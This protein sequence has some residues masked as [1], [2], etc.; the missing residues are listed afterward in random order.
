MLL[1]KHIMMTSDLLATV[2]PPRDPS[3][4]LLEGLHLPFR[5]RLPEEGEADTPDVSPAAFRDYPECPDETFLPCLQKMRSK[6]NKALSMK[7]K[8]SAQ[9]GRL[10]QTIGVAVWCSLSGRTAF[11]RELGCLAFKPSELHRVQPWPT[12]RTSHGARINSSARPRSFSCLC[13]ALTL[14]PLPSDMESSSAGDFLTISGAKKPSHFDCLNVSTLLNTILQYRSRDSKS[15]SGLWGSLLLI[16]SYM[17]E[18]TENTLRLPVPQHTDPHSTLPTLPQDTVRAHTHCLLLLRVTH[19]YAT[20][21]SAHPLGE[22]AT[23]AHHSSPQAPQK[24]GSPQV[25]ALGEWILTLS[26]REVESRSW[27]PSVLL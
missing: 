19:P 10:P 17:D 7:W 14:T 25:C 21:I 3:P 6:K 12:A 5:E 11:R 20:Q 8:F 24:H 2:T 13:P 4:F 15:E 22:A 27:T 18:E 26:H 16:F 1:T 9:A 23:R